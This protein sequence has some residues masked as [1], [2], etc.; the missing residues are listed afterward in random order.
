MTHAPPL[1]VVRSSVAALISVSEN[2][3][4]GCAPDTT[5]LEKGWVLC[6]HDSTDD[7]NVLNL[8]IIKYK[9]RYTMN[10]TK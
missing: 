8:L 10:T 6:Q 2:T 7:S 5:Y 1:Q 4:T 9:M 3:S